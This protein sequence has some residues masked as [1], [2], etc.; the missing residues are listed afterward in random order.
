MNERERNGV[1]GDGR[2]GKSKGIPQWKCI[3]KRILKGREM[4]LGKKIREERKDPE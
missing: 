2:G 3:Q 4:E 1:S